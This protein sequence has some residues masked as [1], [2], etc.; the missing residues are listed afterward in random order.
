MD[1][2]NCKKELIKIIEN[3]KDEILIR[4]LYGII[5]GYNKKESGV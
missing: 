4:I 5:M 3:S 2:K 1:Y